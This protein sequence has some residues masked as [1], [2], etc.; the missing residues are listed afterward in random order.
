MRTKIQSLRRL[1][2]ASREQLHDLSEGFT[3]EEKP[4]YKFLIGMGTMII[5][6]IINFLITNT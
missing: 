2:R 5:F 6:T 3:I 4:N 1:S